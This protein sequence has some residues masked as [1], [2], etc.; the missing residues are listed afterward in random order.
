MMSLMQMA[1]VVA[2]RRIF[3]SWRLELV[4]F[5]GMLLAVALMAS[6]VIFSNLLAEA[7]LRHALNEATPEEANFSVRVF[8]GQKA[9]PTTEG[10]MRHYASNLGF[11]DARVASRVEEFLAEQSLL[12]ETATFFFSGHPKLDLDNDIRPR[13]EIKY[14]S[15]LTGDRTRLV[16][17][18]WPYAAEGS[19]PTEGPLEVAVDTLGASLLG[20]S[21]GGEMNIFPAASFEDPPVAPV[22]IVGVFERMDPEDEYWYRSDRTF[23]FH[24]DQWTI[25]PLFTSQNA[26]LERV[27]RVYPRLYTDITWTYYLDRQSVKAGDADDLLD[28]LLLVRYDVRTNLANSSSRIR[29]DQVLDDYK[30]QLLLARIPLYLIL[31]L[32]IGILTYYLALIASLVVK[33]RAAEISMLKSRG[34]TTPH[35]GLMSF[36]EGILLAIPSTALGPLVALAVVR[37]LGRVFFGLGGSE[38]LVEVPVAL[39]FQSY[40][41]GG[42]GAL[43]GVIVLTVSTLAA[44][45][46]GMV[47]FRQM[48]ARPPQAPF[49][50]RYYLDILLLG[51]IALF[52]WQVQ[53][54]GAFLVRPL[55]SR[56]LEIDYSLLLGPALGLL[57]IGLLVMRFFPIVVGLL[58]RLA[59]P[60]G[61]VWLVHGLRHVSRDPIVPGSLVVLLMFATA[62]G[63]IGSAFSATLERNQE[64]RALYAAGADLRIEHGGSSAPRQLQG[65]SEQADSLDFVD[66]AVEV[67]RT[68][69]HVT[70]TGFS[71]SGT[72]LAVRAE[73]FA[74]VGWYRPDFAGGLTLEELTGLLAPQPRD[75]GAISEGG[76]TDGRGSA[77]SNGYEDGI[78]L[79][80]DATGMSL[81]VQPGRPDN[82]MTL[83]ARMQDNRG[84]YFDTMFGQPGGGSGGIG[85]DFRE[86]RELESDLQPLFRGGANSR[87]AQRFGEPQPPYRLLAI[88]IASRGG[89]PEPGALFL[90]SLKAIAPNGSQPLED[91]R[92]VDG[93]QVIEDYSRPGLFALESSESVQAPEDGSGE[94]GRIRKTARFSWAPGS[95]GMRGIRVLGGQPIESAGGFG[96]EEPPLP[97]LVSR[98]FMEVAD[99]EVGDVRTLGMSTFSLPIEIKAVIDYFPT[100]VPEEKPFAVVD[101]E[102]FTHRSNLHS[103]T[104]IGGTNELWVRLSRDGPSTSEGYGAA[105][106]APRLGPEANLNPDAVDAFLEGNGLRS[107]NTYVASD[108]VR[109]RTEQPLVSAGWGALLVLMFLALV[110]ASASGV[111]LFSFTDTRDRRTEFALLRTLGT[112]RRQLNGAVWFSLFLVTLCGVALGSVAG[113]VIGTSLL[114]L[115]EVAE[116]GARVT[117]PMTL[118]I[119]WFTL[120]VSYA[121]LGSVTIGT[122]LWLIWYTSKMEVQ[123]V[124]R[125]G[126][127]G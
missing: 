71:T 96:R 106:E 6:G 102:T 85:L 50:H 32:V 54:R 21:T 18:R 99:A 67:Q 17:G 7:A 66:V 104:T 8:S 97:A 24:D 87:A 31:F 101:L 38:D 69:G 72:L 89:A 78:L 84:Y 126:E 95:S 116:E 56:G 35:V 60:V 117:P 86:W 29:L 14:L 27:Y 93:W 111:M 91:F 107:R 113:Q 90:S 1:Y 88:H 45:R 80:E 42:A 2:V 9:P 105:V 70:T 103:L 59:E 44:A 112:S 26:I 127:A 98:E 52:W 19:S 65:I 120:A 64:E 34:A 108:M 94:G 79:P 10:R 55:G 46:Q 119:D 49:I 23:S 20:L 3:S 81:Y 40:L 36:I 30:E 83:R 74:N 118:E 110:L 114:P 51:L 33:S 43:L 41:L 122:V 28:T 62:L 13:G 11:A 47:E 4:L 109:E 121:I 77:A 25:V 12:V 5:L 125:I 61:P 53:S 115:M 68:S 39:S 124:L 75:K 48:G 76:P 37:T 100:L 57:A 22:R 123:Q 16:E 82:R 63:V 92:H 15:S 58:A 73:D